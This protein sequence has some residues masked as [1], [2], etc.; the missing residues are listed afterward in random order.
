MKYDYVLDNYLDRFSQ[1]K[2]LEYNDQNQLISIRREVSKIHILSYQ[3]FDYKKQIGQNF[4]VFRTKDF[5][6]FTYDGKGRILRKKI[7][8]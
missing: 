4:E 3:D 1:L 8:R 7:S 2:K 5:T 6:D